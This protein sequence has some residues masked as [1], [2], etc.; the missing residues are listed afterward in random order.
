MTNTPTLIPC[1]HISWEEYI[2]HLLNV[3]FRCFLE[4][5]NSLKPRPNNRNKQHAT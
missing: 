5:Y 2:G 1:T 3:I 4:F